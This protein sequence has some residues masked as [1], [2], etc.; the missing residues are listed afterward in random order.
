MLSLQTNVSAIISQNNL[1]TTSNSLGT[2]MERLS[3]GYRINRAA[4]DAAGLAESEQMQAQIGGLTQAAQN[5]QDG[6]SMIQ[7]GEGALDQI[8]T[9]MQRMRSLAVQAASDTNGQ[10]DRDN[11]NLELQQL[12]TEIDSISQLS[13]FNGQSLLNGSLVTSQIAGTQGWDGAST[14][15]AAS[16]TALGGGETI[17]N[18]DVGGSQQNMGY[19]ISTQSTAGNTIT[20]TQVNS[21]GVTTGMSQTLNLT[22]IAAGQAEAL[23]FA[24]FGVKFTLGN[25]ANAAG[26]VLAGTLVTDLGAGLSVDAGTGASFATLQTGSNQG[27]VTTV[28]FMSTRLTGAT[29]NAPMDGLAQALNAFNTT[30]SADNASSLITAVD[31][32]L[33]SISSNRATLGAA[34]NRLNYTISNLG[35][36]SENLQQ[37]NSRIMD[38][39]VA[40]ESSDMAKEQVLE[41]AGVSVLAQANQL[42]QLALKLLS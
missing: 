33:G 37:A 17:N 19:K 7:T 29:G 2:A 6:I 26:P 4:D 1:N 22:N 24:D 3:S 23:N 18:V 41:Q 42:P 21:S 10:A 9:M 5:S 34:Q 39:D 15:L 32:A 40:T 12:G 36:A 38:V 13:Q 31:N 25:A 20:L 28:Q 8:Q 27:D 35:T 30:A 16:T 14:E 11:I